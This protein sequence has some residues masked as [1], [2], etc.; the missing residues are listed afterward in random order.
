MVDINWTTRVI[1]VFKADMTLVNAGPPEI[2]EFDTAAFYALLKGREA[3]AEGICFP[4]L[5]RHNPPVTVGGLTLG[6]VLEIIDGATILFE[7]GQYRVIL[8]NTNNNLLDVA[9][10]NQVG[11]ATTN[12]IGLQLVE[13]GTSG[14]TPQES[15]AILQNTADLSQ[16]QTDVAQIQVDIGTINTN[17]ATIQGDIATIQTDIGQIRLDITAMQG[18]LSFVTNMERGRWKIV[19]D[20][21]DP[22]YQRMVFYDDVGGV[23]RKFDLFDANG[24]PTTV[25]P[26]ERRPVP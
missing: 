3:D 24:N 7:D 19:T 1:T 9:V 25:N 26:Y 14:L 10:V 17:I 5:H 22:D 13:T 21:G 12:S 23:L 20:S 11:I 15:A 6:R 2:Y 16:L 18:D 4:D 8:Q